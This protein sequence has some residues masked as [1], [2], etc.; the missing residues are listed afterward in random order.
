MYGRILVVGRCRT[1]QIRRRLTQVGHDALARAHARREHAP[2]V[3][4]R[5]GDRVD[6]AAVREPPLWVPPAGPAPRPLAEP[7][8]GLR[9]AQSR[10]GCGR[11]W[12]QSRSRCGRGEP[13]PGADVGQVSP[14]SDMSECGRGGVSPVLAAAQPPRERSATAMRGASTSVAK[15]PNGTKRRRAS[16]VNSGGC[17]PAAASGHREAGTGRKWEAVCANGP[18]EGGP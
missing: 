8:G 4:E 16:A 12:A 14:I 11:R 2:P 1:L 13:S 3:H 15:K 6:A 10:C 18:W 17:G 9:R 7:L 5:R